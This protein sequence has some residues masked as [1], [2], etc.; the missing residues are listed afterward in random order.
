MNPLAGRQIKLA[1]ERSP[2][3]LA[4]HAAAALLVAGIA[5]KQLPAV[6]L[7]AWLLGIAGIATLDC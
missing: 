6:S 2:L 3:D 4:T 1:F 5:T 7:V